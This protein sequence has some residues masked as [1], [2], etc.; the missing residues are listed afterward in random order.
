MLDLEQLTKIKAFPL[1]L[2]QTLRKP[3]KEAKTQR[4]KPKNFRML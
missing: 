1:S 2:S 4:T 3:Q